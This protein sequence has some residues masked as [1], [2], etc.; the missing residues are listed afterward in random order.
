MASSCSGFLRRLNPTRLDAV[1]LAKDERACI[2]NLSEMNRGINE[3]RRLEGDD[4]A[5]TMV[6]KM[7]VIDQTEQQDDSASTRETGES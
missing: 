1:Q 2:S 3:R 7:A 5:V 6:R 4:M